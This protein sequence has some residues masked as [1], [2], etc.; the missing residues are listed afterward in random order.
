MILIVNNMPADTVCGSKSYSSVLK[1]IDDWLI[2]G[3]ANG[4]LLTGILYAA[5]TMWG[6]F[7]YIWMTIKW[8]LTAFM[9][10]TGTFFP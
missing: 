7:R 2:I 6:F 1:I 5:F 10:A 8:I 4:C 3:G 9:I